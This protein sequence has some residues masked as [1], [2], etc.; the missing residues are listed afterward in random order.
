MSLIYDIERKTEEKKIKPHTESCIVIG[1]FLTVY[2]VIL[3][4]L[5]IR[6]RTYCE[7]TSSADYSLEP[8]AIDDRNSLPAT[9]LHGLV[10]TIQAQRAAVD[11]K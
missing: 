8:V 7:E 2:I 3:C 9:W 10:D 5:L 1:L 4:G 11:L 6:N